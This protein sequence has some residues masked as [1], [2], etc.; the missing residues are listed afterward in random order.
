MRKVVGFVI[1][2]VFSRRDLLFCFY[3]TKTLNPAN[4]WIK[5]DY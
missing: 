2:T 5:Y 4:N 1:K 3:K